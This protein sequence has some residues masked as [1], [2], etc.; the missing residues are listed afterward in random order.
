MDKGDQ[1]GAQGDSIWCPRGFS[2]AVSSK[3]S[4]LQEAEEEGWVGRLG[5][6]DHTLLEKVIEAGV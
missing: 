3:R 6:T 4:G 1:T 2:R 5:Q